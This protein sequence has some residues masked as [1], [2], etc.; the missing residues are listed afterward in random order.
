MHL[1]TK[2]AYTIYIEPMP[3]R[4][5]RI[6]V[7]M[8]S[9]GQLVG[10]LMDGAVVSKYALPMCLNRT[11]VNMSRGAIGDFMYDQ[12]LSVRKDALDEFFREHISASPKL[13]DTWV[14][15]CA[16]PTH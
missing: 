3:S 5:Y 11:V 2:A 12:S 10:P 4:L 8:K 6:K 14:T 1:K 15:A 16:E 9:G 7:Q 13:V